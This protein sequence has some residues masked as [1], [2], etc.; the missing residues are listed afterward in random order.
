MSS[1]FSFPRAPGEENMSMAEIFATLPQDIQD[2]LLQSLTED[3]VEALRYDADF[4]LRPKQMIDG[5]D[6]YI[7]ALTAGRGFGKGLEL[8]TKLLTRN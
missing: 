4:W 1:S 5:D 6:W 2:T 8:S 7:T 3:Q